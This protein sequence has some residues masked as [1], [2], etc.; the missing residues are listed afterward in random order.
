LN[1][2]K[3]INDLTKRIDR[4]DLSNGNSN[5]SNYWRGKE[6][7]PL[8]EWIQLKGMPYA[9][10]CFPDDFDK[11]QTFLTE[12]ELK[13]SDEQTRSWYSNYLDLMEYRRNLNYGKSKCFH[14]L[15]S[16]DRDDPIFIGI[17]RLV[18]KGLEDNDDDKKNNT[19]L[20]PCHV[21]NRFECPYEIGKGLDTRFNVE[22]LFELANMAFAVE[23]AL[24]VA[25][26]VTSSVQIK[27]KRDLY[28]AL[29]NREI[30]DIILK[31][32]YEYVLSDKETFND[33][34]RFEQLQKGNRDKIVDYFVS[35][36][37]KIILGDLRF[38]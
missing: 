14:C 20:C 29:T 9:L 38:Y 28:Q 19:I 8:D 17:N 35:I 21:E 16:P 31:Q 26:K 18:A 30:L 1:L 23:I 11:C 25:R 7:I 22:N 32:G 13:D 2:D 24:A 3:S 27:N 10:E 37:D 15:L 4:F 5:D 36:K 34:S 12:N 6:I 33:V